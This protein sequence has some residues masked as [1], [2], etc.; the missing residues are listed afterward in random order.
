MGQIW[1]TDSSM[2]QSTEPRSWDMSSSKVQ[3][4]VRDRGAR[5]AAVQSVGSQRVAHDGVTDIFSPITSQQPLEFC[6]VQNV[7]K[8]TSPS[9]PLGLASAAHDGGLSSLWAAVHPRALRL[10]LPAAEDSWL[11]PGFVGHE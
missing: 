7:C 1:V 3:E 9:E 6:L 4:M 2:D 11:V 5:H 8:G 10:H